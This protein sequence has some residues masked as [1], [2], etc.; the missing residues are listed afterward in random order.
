MTITIYKND[1]PSD[2]KIDGDI[3]VDTEAMG[4]N[5]HRDRLCVLQFSNGDGNA[6]LV[7]FDGEDY[8]APNLIKLLADENKQKIFHYARFDVAIIKHYLGVTFDNI[9]CTKLASKLARTYSQ[10]HSLKELCRE[11][12]GVSLSKQQQS[13]DWG[14][15]ELTPEQQ[16]YAA[17]DVLYLHK[18]RDKLIIM[19]EREG[20]EYLAYEL[21]AFL[22]TRTDL[23][24]MG[25]GDDNKPDIFSYSS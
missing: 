6:Y 9:F 19:L 17:R 2:F 13:S 1:I 14:N 23:D 18:I 22:G 21:F 10:S 15:V 12:A 25:F 7:V 4:L 16:E 24:I 20:R 3:A 11:L 8:S 5:V